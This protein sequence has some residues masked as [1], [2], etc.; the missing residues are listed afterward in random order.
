MQVQALYRK[1]LDSGLSPTTVRKVLGFSTSPRRVA[2]AVQGHSGLRLP[3]N[4]VL[5]GY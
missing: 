3:Y 2:E 1:R 5:V 4:P